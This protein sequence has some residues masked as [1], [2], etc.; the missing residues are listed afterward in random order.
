MPSGS[1]KIFSFLKVFLVGA[2]KPSVAHKFAEMKLMRERDTEINLDT[3]RKSKLLLRERQRE[4]DRGRQTM[5]VRD[6]GRQ[7]TTNNNKAGK[8][9]EIKNVRERKNEG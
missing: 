6:R 7:R 4:R 2:L 3:E 8:D 5:R 1:L 9:K